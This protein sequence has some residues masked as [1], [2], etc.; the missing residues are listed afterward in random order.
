MQQV[1]GEDPV[2]HTRGLPEPKMP[3]RVK[4]KDYA[5]LLPEPICKFTGTIQDAEHLSF[6]QGGGHGG[7]EH[8][9]VAHRDQGAPASAGEDLLRPAG[10]VGGHAGNTQGQGL[11]QHVGGALPG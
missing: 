6:I 11:G 7:C 2:I 3:T 9:I 5:H 1:E 10:A 8:G 4:V